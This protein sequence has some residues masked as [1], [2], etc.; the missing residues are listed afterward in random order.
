MV[1]ANKAEIT[2]YI[3]VRQGISGNLLTGTVEVGIEPDIID[4]YYPAAVAMCSK[5]VLNPDNPKNKTEELGIECEG[6]SDKESP[7]IVS[8]Q[9]DV[10]FFAKGTWKNFQTFRNCK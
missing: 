2:S 3:S 5:C 8:G 4:A 1:G 10:K 7:N 9:T 6:L